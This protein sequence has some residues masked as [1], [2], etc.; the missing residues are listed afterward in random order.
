MDELKKKNDEQAKL[1]AKMLSD[2]ANIEQTG[3]SAPYKCSSCNTRVS[4]TFILPFIKATGLC[5]SCFHNDGEE[6]PKVKELQDQ[7][8]ALKNGK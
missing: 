7:I 4:Y 1:I 2:N 8:K 6:D 3:H 5:P